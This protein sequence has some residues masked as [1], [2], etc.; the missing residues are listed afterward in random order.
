[1]IAMNLFKSNLIMEWLFF[2]L[3]DLQSMNILRSCSMN[4]S[5]LQRRWMIPIPLN[6]NSYIFGITRKIDTTCIKA[7]KMISSTISER[8]SV[9]CW[10]ET[11]KFASVF[12]LQHS[13]SNI[14]R[15]SKNIDQCVLSVDATA[16]HRTLAEAAG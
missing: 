5:C 3:P 9:E 10:F 15:K 6:N 2:R 4:W 12:C 8:S 14:R 16:R 1:M 11:I 7:L 13:I